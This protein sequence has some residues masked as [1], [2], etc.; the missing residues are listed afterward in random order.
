MPGHLNQHVPSTAG[1]GA[2]QA[3]TAKRSVRLLDP[4]GGGVHA[5]AASTSTT[6]QAYDPPRPP[7]EGCEWVWFPAGYWAERD[8]I[9]ISP[10]RKP[11]PSTWPFRWN[12]RSVKESTG[13]WA[14]ESPEGSPQ[15]PVESPLTPP[16]HLQKPRQM[17]P[18]ASP[19]LSE[20]AHVQSLQHP[21]ISRGVSTDSESSL[22]VLGITRSEQKAPLSTP[23][24]SGTTDDPIEEA[25][26]QPYDIQPPAPTSHVIP[27]HQ[28]GDKGDHSS[29][30][31]T[32]KLF[33]MTSK[34]HQTSASSS[35]SASGSSLVR[36]RNPEVTTPN[37]E[38]DSYFAPSE[39]YPGGEARRVKTPP[40]REAMSD[41]RPRSFFFDIS[42]PPSPS[43]IHDVGHGR[44]HQKSQHLPNALPDDDNNDGLPYFGNAKQ[45]PNSNPLPPHGPV[46]SRSLRRSQDAGGG[47]GG[48]IAN[49]RPGALTRHE[50]ARGQ[51]EEWQAA[52]PPLPPPNS[53]SQT[54]HGQQQQ[55]QPRKTRA[56]AQVNKNNPNHS[57]HGK[58]KDWREV[59]VAVDSY[60]GMAPGAFAFDLPEHLPSSPMCPA[61]KKHV[62]GGTGV[63]VYHG[64]RKRSAGVDDDD[65][66]GDVGS[67][68][69]SNSS[70]DG[71]WR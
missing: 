17:P 39:L 31:R 27:K 65:D 36:A 54:H 5:P 59:P 43:S 15:E 19:F 25:K 47:V 20:A 11:E 53:L 1:V 52:A 62:S 44:M 34:S 23:W 35:I 9:E 2:G 6:S 51:Q 38:H 29:M 61:N 28:D 50:T 45:P 37:L 32:R 69:W 18:L 58:Q 30:T 33:G 56:Q 4:Q 3:L 71:N 8:V 21:G 14:Q 66:E 49:V 64:R 7:K 26:P 55:Q 67:G 13:G 42:A 46:G 57:H 22:H 70:G 60:E 48:G 10:T 24:P 63:C 40:L 16:Q 12:K 41:G 68:G